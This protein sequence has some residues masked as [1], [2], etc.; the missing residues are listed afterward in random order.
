MTER[1]TEILRSASEPS[2]SQAVQ[3]RFVTELLTGAI[4]DRVIAGYLIQ[5]SGV[6]FD[7]Q[8]VEAFLKLPQI[9]QR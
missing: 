1:F 9:T 6:L 7:P 8:V 2:W 3:H 4:S 5:Q